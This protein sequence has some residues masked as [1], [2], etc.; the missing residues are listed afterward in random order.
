MSSRGFT[1][2]CECGATHDRSACVPPLVFAF[3][4]VLVSEHVSVI[5]CGCALC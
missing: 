1:V 5:V 4:L 2:L 3:V